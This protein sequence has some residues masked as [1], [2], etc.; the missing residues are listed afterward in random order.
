M[1]LEKYESRKTIN[2]EKHRS[3]KNI[4]LEKHKSRKNINLEK[5]HKSIKHL[6]VSKG[7]VIGATYSNACLL[8][9]SLL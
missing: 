4:D 7:F 6:N 8:C 5:K 1:N 2:L 9:T 3:R